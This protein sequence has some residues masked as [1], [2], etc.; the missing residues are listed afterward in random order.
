MKNQGENEDSKT[1]RLCGRI[2]K[3]GTTEHHLIPRTCHKNK[4][5]KKNF[6]RERM[7]ET[8]SLCRDCHRE[9]HKQVPREKE[10]GRYFNTVESL[11]AH[12]EIGKFVAWVSKQK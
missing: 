10:L 2:T 8:I 3:G 11:L 4:W 9:L 6:S 7:A 1:C 5:F 12:E